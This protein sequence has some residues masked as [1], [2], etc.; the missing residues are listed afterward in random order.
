[1]IGPLNT[2]RAAHRATL[3]PNGKV[4]IA[5]GAN[6]FIGAYYSSTEL[7]IPPVPATTIVL[8]NPTRLPNGTFVFTFTNA[9][10]ATF[11]ALATTTVALA[12]T[13]WTALGAVT[14]ISPGNFQFSDPQAATNL[15]RFYEVK[16]N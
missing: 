7:L 8:T 1:M 9:P 13:N 12:R 3:L 5:C 10:G 11:T 4:L 15:L 14:E 2:Q 6:V 16:A